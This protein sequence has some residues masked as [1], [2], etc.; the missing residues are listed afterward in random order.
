MGGV[1]CFWRHTNDVFSVLNIGNLTIGKDLI[2]SM[3]PS[4]R[5]GVRG[6]VSAEVAKQTKSSLAYHRLHETLSYPAGHG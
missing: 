3:E 4:S 5:L 2:S 6:L 1:C